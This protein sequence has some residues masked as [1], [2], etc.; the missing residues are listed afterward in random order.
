MVYL[1]INTMTK[2]LHKVFIRNFAVQKC[3]HLHISI[4]Q[5]MKRLS[6]LLAILVALLPMVAKAQLTD[7]DARAEVATST[8]L[9]E[10]PMTDA[11][12]TKDSVVVSLLT[13]TPGH[14]IYELYGHTAIRVK[15][16]GSRQSDWVFNYG[17]FSFE[18]PH[19]MWRFV[20]GQT[21]YELCVVPYVYFY[22][23]YV[24]EGRG[25]DEQVLNLT[26][27]EARRLVDALSNNLLPQNATYRYD[28]FNDNCTTRAISMIERAV[29]GKVVW[30]K[31]EKEQS[32]RN[33]VDEFSSTSPWNRFGQ[34]LL[35]GAEA[36]QKANLRKQM[37]A[38]IYAEHYMDK[39][40]VKSNDGSTRQLVKA[41]RTL[42]P[43]Q[44]K[45]VKTFPI[46]P[47]WFFG[48][49]FVCSIVVSAI[50]YAR[51][52][53]YWQFDV[54]LY[55]AQ[56]LTGCVTAFLFFFSEHPTVGTNWLVLMFNP[57][58]L[59]FFAWYMKKAVEHSRCWS[60]WVE[61]IMLIATLFV[62]IAGLQHFPVEVYLIIATLAV[63]IA[64]QYVSIPRIASTK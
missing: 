19:F 15:E 46:S 55:L 38:P 56:G 18:Q 39:A 8:S 60:M 28:F 57:L 26:V 17:S 54:L 58:P 20:L 3:V 48:M 2:S 64:A 40:L 47:M 62:G 44:P 25:I 52:R 36:D 21:D 33:I 30:P 22:D 4:V 34:N 63:R 24:R 37:F 1:S 45:P 9:E 14:L 53:F 42:L 35:L 50:E 16:L 59:V 61:A 51:H 31:E 41:L 23:A 43:E 6:Y 29:D 7:R 32:L 11:T 13:C 10:Q 5:F 12:A 27:D 49:L